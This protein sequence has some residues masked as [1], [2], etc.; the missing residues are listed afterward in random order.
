MTH[1]DQLVALVADHLGFAILEER[2]ERA[3]K[4]R[5]DLLAEFIIGSH[6]P[7]DQRSVDK[8][9]GFIEGVRWF[10]H[11]VRTKDSEL[12]AEA[13]QDVEDEE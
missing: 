8:E 1:D 2:A 10:F 4:K 13:T 12:R 9:R 5:A 7:L 3:I 11:E 6:L